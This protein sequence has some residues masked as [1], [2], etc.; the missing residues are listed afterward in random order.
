MRRR[1]TAARGQ[2]SEKKNAEER[3]LGPHDADI[4]RHLHEILHECE[5]K[6]PENFD[7]WT[8]LKRPAKS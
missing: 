4:E 1:A 7:S 2:R 3:R 5:R 6:G 8:S